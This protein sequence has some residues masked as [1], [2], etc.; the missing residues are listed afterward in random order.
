MRKINRIFLIALLTAI[1]H[2]TDTLVYAVRLSGVTTRRLA[3]AF[4]L[5]QII[6]LLASTANLVQA[7]LLSSVVESSINQG[8]EK[9]ATT[10]RQLLESPF[11]QQQLNQLGF[12]IRLI[13]LAATLGTI[14]GVIFTPAFNYVFTRVIL[15]FEEAGSVPRLVLVVLSPRRLG[16]ALRKRPLHVTAFSNAVKTGRQRSIPLSFLTANTAVIGIWTTGVLSALYAGALLPDYRS[17]ASLLSG[18]VNGLA[19]ILS[20]MIV[21]PTAAMIT[22]QAIRGQRGPGDVRQMVYYLCLTRILGTILAQILFLPAAGFIKG[23]ALLMAAP[24]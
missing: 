2:L 12:D 9:A 24:D 4:S 17:T 23:V 16:R 14:A 22:D 6:A 11:Y 19:T 5:F 1:I 15:L 8:M 7:P 20:A 3:T 13:I 18:V 21:D 10:G